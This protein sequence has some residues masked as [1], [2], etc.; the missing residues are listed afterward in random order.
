LKISFLL[1]V[2]I[3]LSA[4]RASQS[5]PAP[6][7]EFIKIPPQSE[8]GSD[9][10][11]DIEGTVS[12]SKPGQQI[13]LYSKSGTWWVQPWVKR[14]FTGIQP[15]FRWQNSIHGGTEFAALLVE[16]DYRPLSRTDKLP[17]VGDGVVAVSAVKGTGDPPVPSNRI[18][19]SGY[20]W[21]ARRLS[22]DR[23][24]VKTVFDPANAWTDESGFLHL[25]VTNDSGELKS[26]QVELMTTLGYGTYIFT[27]GDISRMDLTCILSLSTYDRLESGQNHREMMIDISP[28]SGKSN[29]NLSYLIQPEYLPTNAAMFNVPTSGALT[30]SFHW[31]QGKVKFKTVRG[32]DASSAETLAEHTFTL[33]IPTS[34]GERIRIGLLITDYSPQS[35]QKETEVVIEKF[36][37]LP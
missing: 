25:R 9:K 21:F 27:V 7:I 31:Q 18:N 30:H 20:Q 33:G 28:S 6:S 35:L 22:T 13:V 4:C 17:E 2:L 15:D 5:D 10:L 36:E 26:A 12:S 19:F 32:R 14:P 23:R 1:I 34:E 24:S 29:K 37:Y 16:P 11:F 8:G 3:F